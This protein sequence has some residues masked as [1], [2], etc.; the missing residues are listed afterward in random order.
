[1]SRFHVAVVTGTRAEFGIWRPVLDALGESRVLKTSLLVTGMHLLR[2]FGNTQRDITKQGYKVAARIPMYKGNEPAARSLARAIEGFGKVFSKLKPDLVYLLGDRLEMLAAANA[3]LAVRIPI[4]HLHGGESARG[5]WDEQIRHAISKMAHVH[6]CAT[7]VAARR[8]VQMGEPKSRVH[9]VGA[10]AL[11]TAVATAEKEPELVSLRQDIGLNLHPLL[12]LHPSCDDEKVEYQRTL[13]LIDILRGKVANPDKIRVIG[14]NNDP[15]HR[16]ILRAYRRRMKEGKIS[17]LPSLTQD[18]FWKFLMV[19]GLLIGNSSSGIIEA[20]SF[21]V[22]VVNVGDR[23]ARRERN[24]NV[25]DVGWEK[26]EIAAAID[27]ALHDKAFLRQVARRRNIYGNGQAAAQIT[28][29]LELLAQS[30]I[31]LEKQFS[32]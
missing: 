21:G 23:Q 17:M 7:A 10:P 6:F 32:E 24:R 12:L 28:K 8:L 1:V 18:L 16:G 9:C 31:P 26:M 15:G 11:D 13:L 20:A 30:Q 27:K 25:I 19:S 22:P 5:I 29:I 4:A 3:A 2:E 14:P